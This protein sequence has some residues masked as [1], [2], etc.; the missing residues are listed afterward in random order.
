MRDYAFA[1]YLLAYFLRLNA[2]LSGTT[3]PVATR[4]RILRVAK[5]CRKPK[6]FLFLTRLC[7]IS[8]LLVF[9]HTVSYNETREEET[10]YEIRDTRF[11]IQISSYVASSRLGE[12]R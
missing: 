5:T 2:V 10:R 4:V 6:V 7:M 12:I 9:C 1:A 8:V 11:G 3:P